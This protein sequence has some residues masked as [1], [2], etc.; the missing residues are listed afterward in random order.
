MLL[1]YVTSIFLGFVH[2]CSKSLIL[3]VRR[4]DDVFSRN[5]IFHL[6]LEMWEEAVEAVVE[7]GGGDE[8]VDVTDAE[9]TIPVSSVVVRWC[10]M[11]GWRDL[12]MLATSRHGRATTTSSLDIIHESR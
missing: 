11:L 8:R 12:Q 3:G 2:A 4:G 6:G 10:A 9:P 5:R 1:V 7:D